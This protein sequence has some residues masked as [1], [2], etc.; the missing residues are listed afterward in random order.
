MSNRST[1]SDSEAPSGGLSKGDVEQLLVD[2]SADSRISVMSKIADKYNGGEF[3]EKEFIFAEQIFRL[4][5]K[6]A[7]VKVREAL[8]HELKANGDI[9]R[10][11]VL[12]MAKDVEQVSLPVLEASDVLSDA[13]LVQIVESSR[14]V[15]KLMAIAERGQVSGRV[16]EAL[17]ESQCEEAV[18]NLLKNEGAEI[19][20]DTYDQILTEYADSENITGAMSERAAIPANIVEKLVH[21]VSDTV[22]ANL[23]EKYDIGDVSVGR[24]SREA[25]TL[26]LLS[27]NQPDEE[28]DRT[29]IQMIN[30]GR[31]SPSM[32]LSALCRG[33]LS[34]F[35]I[36]LARLAGIPRANARKLIHDKGPLGFKALYSKTQLP[37][38]MFD[39]VRLLMQMVKIMQDEG[40][41]PGGAQYANELVNRTLEAAKDRD[42]ENLPYVIALIRQAVT[43]N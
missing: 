37:E 36:S 29:V 5:M 20:E 30:S 18:E 19:P 28:I 16:S 21:F 31:L 3:Q 33:H 39:A 41:S 43:A 25:T 4:M 13:D 14:E 15:S 9:P 40:I 2:S 32:I 26:D 12:H 34:F 7:E 6:D 8:S 17:V 1:D 10:D 22:A 24:E 38:S 11:I 23:K 42:I 35:E 27:Y